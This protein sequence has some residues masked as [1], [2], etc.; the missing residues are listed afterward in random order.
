MA[1]SRRG[2]VRW[3]SPLRRGIIR[4]DSFKISRSLHQTLR[5]EIFQVRLNE[6]F[7]RVMREC[8]RRED[9]WISEDIV[10]SYLRLHKLGYGHSVEAWKEGALAGG[11][12]GVALGAA[13]FGESMFSLERDA[14]KVA[15]VRLV[16]RLKRQRFELLDTQFITPHLARFGA[17]EISRGEY[18]E[19][20]RSAIRKKREFA[21]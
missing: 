17:V 19:L 2:E 3:Y 14:S 20:L 13:F 21:G 15:L 5:K 11:L 7:E 9:T 4:L 16:E 12:Y 1:D 6:S 18:L 10:Q 8:A